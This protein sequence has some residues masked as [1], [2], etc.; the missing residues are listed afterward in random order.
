MRR[1]PSPAVAV[2][3]PGA[4]GGLLA[5]RWAKSLPVLL[6]GRSAAS[7]SRLTKTGITLINP[8]GSRQKI[9]RGLRSA[10]PSSRKCAAAVFCVKSHDTKKAIAAARRFIGPD[11]AVISLQ[12]GLGHERL[13]R[14]AFGPSRTVI[15][16]CYIAADRK[17]PDT[18]IHGGGDEVWLASNAQNGKALSVARALIKQG[19]W[20]VRVKSNEERLLWTKLCFNAATNPLGT[21][22][23]VPNG[24]LASNPVLNQLMLALIDEIMK[25]AKKSGHRALYFNIAKVILPACQAAPHQRNSMLQDVQAGRKTEVDAILGPLLAAER[26]AKTSAPLLNSLYR[27]LKRL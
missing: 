10:R 20:K 7:E 17:S 25:V 23:A 15:G 27:I 4:V 1:H 18:I 9:R 6:L 22:C 5:A 14:Q 12:N 24:E 2:V 19:G 26:H 16:V 8:D 13:L 3:G 21:L 11:T